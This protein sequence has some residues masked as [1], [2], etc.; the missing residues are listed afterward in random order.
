MK[1]IVVI[2]DD[3]GNNLRE[4]EIAVTGQPATQYVFAAVEEAML[5][6]LGKWSYGHALMAEGAKVQYTLTQ[7]V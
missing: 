1:I 4:C 5:N 6:L 2:R 3:Q 7:N